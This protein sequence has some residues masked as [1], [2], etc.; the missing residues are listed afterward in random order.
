LFSIVHPLFSSSASRI[1]SRSMHVRRMSVPISE[2]IDYMCLNW[3]CWSFL[4]RSAGSTSRR[5]GLGSRVNASQKNIA[6]T[7]NRWL[8]FLSVVQSPLSIIFDPS[9]RK[10]RD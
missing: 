3:I 9:L 8:S 10:C 1:M 2:S 6:G 7:G 4:D 5:K